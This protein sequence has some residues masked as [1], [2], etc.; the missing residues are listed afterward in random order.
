MHVSIW[1]FTGDPDELTASY[2]AL[3]S[4]FPTD[5]FVAHLC[6]LDSDGLVIVDTCPTREAFEAF[7]SSEEFAEARRRHGLPDPTEVRGYPVHAA[8]LAGVE[9]AAAPA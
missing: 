9:Q 4:E 7:A 1:K 8:Y 6:L 3:L 5:Q 2:D